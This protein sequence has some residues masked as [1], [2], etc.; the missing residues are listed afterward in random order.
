MLSGQRKRL[1]CL[2]V[3]TML[4]GGAGVSCVKP[5]AQ[6]GMES[7]RASEADARSFTDVLAGV[8]SG[9]GKVGE[10]KAGAASRRVVVF[11]EMHTSVLGQVETALMLLRLHDRDGLRHVLLEG[12]TK[13][14]KFP[15][16][17]WFR[18]LGG[19]DN[20]LRNELLVSLLRQGEISAVEL[21]ALA[22][23]D[24]VVHAAEDPA[25]YAVELTRRGEIATT[26][27]LYKI[28]L[29]SV[30]PE[31]MA[32][33]RQ[34]SQQ[35]KMQELIEYVISLDGWAKQRYEQGKNGRGDISAEQLLSVAQEIEERAA[36]VGAEITDE[37]RA[38]MSEM[39][40]FFKAADDRTRVMVNTALGLDESV[41]LMA[42][43][44][45]AAHTERT[46]RLLG[47]AG[48]TYGLLTPVSLAQNLEN[49]ELSREAF[50]R[51]GKLQSVAFTDYGLSSLLDGRKKT[52][53]V[54]DTPW[55]KGYSH[56][57]V[58]LIYIGRNLDD[59]N[60]P[61]EEL[62]RKVSA[63]EPQVKVDWAGIVRKKERG[64]STARVPLTVSGDKGTEAISGWCRKEPEPFPV[65]Y[66]Q[67]RSLEESL[68]A[69]RESVLMEKGK[70][71]KPDQRKPKQ[72]SPAVE[73]PTPD[74]L[75]AF[76]KDPKVFDN[77][78]PEEHYQ[79]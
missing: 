9:V 1:S 57:Q 35:K 7:G 70:R 60:F 65:T 5:G 10:T 53:P 36:A 32:R 16:T 27:Y 3:V 75:T 17:Q 61:S 11:E 66:K 22:F 73:R 74:V 76:S 42:L 64:K 19:A 29:K 68:V 31:H 34:L 79:L 41:S 59:P 46:L 78:V 37:D 52:P 2:L 71:E 45:G 72:A 33:I 24:V 6:A 58:A 21:I 12:L 23:P 40:A 56:A 18:D 28:A 44:I 14:K 4:F 20:E 30:R 49:G 15:E 47:D 43:N 13:D 54:V 55:F 67:G 38:A 69:L 63:L 26:V 48:V 50:E 51:K 77:F 8:S 39:K 62:K 25:L